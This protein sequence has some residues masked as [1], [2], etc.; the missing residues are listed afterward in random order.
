VV[1]YVGAGAATC[2]SDGLS[3][4]CIGNCVTKTT[5]EQQMIRGGFD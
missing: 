3:S 1:E 2:G 5:P 4:V